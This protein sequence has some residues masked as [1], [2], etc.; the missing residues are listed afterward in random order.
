MDGCRLLCHRGLCIHTGLSESST[1]GSHHHW[2]PRPDT[3]FSDGVRINRRLLCDWRTQIAASLDHGCG[4][5]FG[6]RV[7]RLLLSG[8]RGGFRELLL[9]RFVSGHRFPES[10]LT[11]FVVWLSVA[12]V[13]PY[14]WFRSRRRSPIESP[15][16]SLLHECWF[17]Q[18]HRS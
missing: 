16:L 1:Y 7:C 9:R 3:D 4:R 5:G 13:D 15:P 12:L 17:V 2:W 8:K 11:V 6:D 14:W 10:Q 18:Q